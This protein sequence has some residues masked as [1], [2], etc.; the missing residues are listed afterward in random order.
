MGNWKRPQPISTR[1][2]GEKVLAWAP[3]HRDEAGKR[4]KDASRAPTKLRPTPKNLHVS[5]HKR[6]AIEAARYLAKISRS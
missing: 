5:K 6:A 4:V 3:K 2:V 1:G